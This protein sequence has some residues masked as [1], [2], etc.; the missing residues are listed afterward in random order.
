MHT[1]IVG[2]GF[3]GSALARLLLRRGD[4]VVLA[5]RHPSLRD[6]DLPWIALDITDLEQ[7]AEMIHQMDCDAIVLVHGPSDVSWCEEHAEQALWTHEVSAQN[8]VRSAGERRVIM[9]STDNVFDGTLA[10][11][12]EDTPVCPANNY[13]KAKLSAEAILRPLSNVSVL[14]VSLIYGWDSEENAQWLNFFASSVHRLRSGQ[15]VAA[16]YDQWCTPVLLE[17]VVSVIAALLTAPEVPPLLH[18]GGPERVSRAEWA[19]LIAAGSD[20]SPEMVIP[21]PRANG[22]YA[23]RPKNSC[24]ASKLLGRH[25]ATAA[26][27]VRG[28]SEGTALLLH[29]ICR[30]EV[31][32]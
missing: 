16:P 25:P 28:V 21:E 31:E 8:I 14:R 30:K 7:C 3:V 29:Q 26:I 6:P 20:M 15:R 2:S 9:I 18:L 24:L 5:S 4:K 22:R 19:S 27:P 32:A 23:S 12:E 17:D 13:G 11:P 10:A 1:L